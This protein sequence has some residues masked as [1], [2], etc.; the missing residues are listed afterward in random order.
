MSVRPPD[1]IRRIVYLGTP[2][3]AVPPLQALVDAGY[4]IPLVVSRAD[5]RRG[6]GKDLM[7]SP[8]KAA[9]IELG[10]PVTDQ[11]G[12]I[13]DVEADLAVVVAYGR[14]IPKAMLDRL[15]FVNI[16]FSLLPRWRGAA[17]VERA[18]LAGDQV[19]GVCLMDLD[20]AL[21]TGAI[22]RRSE[23]PIGPD[24]TLGE[25]RGRLV[26]IGTAQLVTALAE[27]LGTPSAQEGDP[28]YA[29]KITA[30][31]REIDWDLPAVA[32]HRRVRVGG[33]FTSW[34]GKRFKIHRTRL[35][36]PG[37][38]GVVVPTGEGAL[39][40]VEV[41]AEGKPRMEAASWANGARWSPD[42]VFGT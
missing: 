26:E 32:I 17:P 5:A 7:A 40:L 23:T 24:E 9:A 31:E 12:D 14:I 10:L 30:A 36:E 42:Q 20:E 15:A 35:A 2:G 18:I 16:H 11:L 37:A 19:T 22:Y 28:V 41:Q 21:D 33:A 6:R 29:A 39:E 25:L 34:N 13:D 1:T 38:R 3:L 4:E 27:G 8:V